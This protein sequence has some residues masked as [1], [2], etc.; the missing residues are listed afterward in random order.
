LRDFHLFCGLV[1]DL[2]GGGVFLNIGSAVILPEVF[3]KAVSLVRNQGGR[4]DDFSTAV[5]DFLKQYRPAENVARRPLGK[6]GR[7]SISSAPTRSSSRCWRPRSSLSPRSPGLVE[8]E[9]GDRF[10]PGRIVSST[11]PDVSIV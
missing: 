6:K 4:L 2:N 8:K 10:G 9:C 5:F 7:D 11:A 1:R 3:L